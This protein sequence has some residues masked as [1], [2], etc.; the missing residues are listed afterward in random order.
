MNPAPPVTK[1]LGFVSLAIETYS[2][3]RSNFSPHT[4]ITVRSGVLSGF[5]EISGRPD[6]TP[7]LDSKDSAEAKPAGGSILNAGPASNVPR[8]KNAVNPW[9]SGRFCANAGP[10]VA[11]AARRSAPVR[12]CQFWCQLR[13]SNGALRCGTLRSGVGLQTFYSCGFQ[14][15]PRFVA[16]PGVLLQNALG[17]T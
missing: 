4:C 13:L 11:V 14:H 7:G 2:Y 8:F 5:P 17:G 6:Y 3:L 16:L 1:L 10:P 12:W 15:M 9:A